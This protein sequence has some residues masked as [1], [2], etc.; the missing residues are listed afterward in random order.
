NFHGSDTFTYSARDAASNSATGIVT[1]TVVDNSTVTITA[2]D[3]AASTN[4][5][6]ASTPSRLNNA[7][8]SDGDALSI[9]A[10]TQGA[11]GTVT[12]DGASVTYTPNANFHGSDSFTYTASDAAGNSATAMVTITVVDNSTVTI[13]AGDMAAST[14]ENTAVTLSVLDNASDSDGDALS[15]SAVSQAAF[16]TVSTDGTSVTYTPSDPNFQG[17]DTFTYTASDAAGNSATAT[18]TITVV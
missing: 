1:I 18:V 11:F 2:G 14:N 3:T 10:V 16:G 17:T 13:T 5:N 15:I 7:S 8:D 9:S 12:I 4:E 6:T